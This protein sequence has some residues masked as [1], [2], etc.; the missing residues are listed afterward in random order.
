MCLISMAVYDT[1]ANQRT[2]YTKATLD[3]L[4]S[5]VD[6][7]RHRLFI[8]DNAS[9]QATK[10]LIDSFV[11]MNYSKNIK[12][13]TLPK[14]LG[15]AEGL[16]QAWQH[17]FPGEHCIKIDND[18]IVHESGW[19]DKLVES[20]DREP[21]LGLI[22][23]KRSDLGEAPWCQDLNGRTKL[24]MLN[25]NDKSGTWIV[26]EVPV[27]S[28]RTHIMG[29][30]LLHSSNLLDKIGYLKQIGVYGWEDTLMALRSALAGFTNAFYPNVRISHIDDGSNPYQKEKERSA[31][32]DVPGMLELQTGYRNGSIPLKYD[33]FKK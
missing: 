23:L 30:C 7:T 25:Q 21:N 26:L 2:K 10:D 28:K 3:G 19:V 14:N 29:T 31:G 33:P 24:I 27:D 12:V 5:T 15:T 32:V 16:N 17:R 22:A 8:V 20:A 6:L 13:I 1:E 18:V 9:C 11:R 4:I